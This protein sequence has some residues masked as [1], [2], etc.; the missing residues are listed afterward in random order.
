MN[1]IYAYNENGIYFLFN[2]RLWWFNGKRFEKWCYRQHTYDKIFAHDGKLYA[3]SRNNFLY[4]LENN[5]FKY[6][7]GS[8]ETLFKIQEY[9]MNPWR[10]CF[11][12]DKNVYHYLN[13]HGPFK[14]NDHLLP[15][16][17]YYNMGHK[18][19][20]FDNSLYYFSFEQNGKNETF[21]IKTNQWALFNSQTI[22]GIS[23]VNLLN[24]LFYVLFRNGKI[25]TYNSKSDSWQLLAISLHCQS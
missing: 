25:G 12:N 22:H 2:D 6:H 5:K 21:N 14:K 18:L 10:I 1:I 16:K 7:C 9:F 11:A 23:D 8:L 13:N 20:Y 19:S 24:E 4:I 3:I 15:E 17:K